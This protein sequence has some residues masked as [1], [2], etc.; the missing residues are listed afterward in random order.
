MTYLR[1]RNGLAELCNVLF[2]CRTM[3]Q[4]IQTRTARQDKSMEDFNKIK[5]TEV[6]LRTMQFDGIMDIE[7]RLKYLTDQGSNPLDYG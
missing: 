1:T 5:G 2:M 6:T 4:V 3:K 7:Q